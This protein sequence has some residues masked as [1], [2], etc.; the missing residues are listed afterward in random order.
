MGKIK[1]IQPK[2]YQEVGAEFI[3]FGWVAKSWLKSGSYVHNSI[4]LDFID[5]DGQ[6]FIGSSIGVFDD[7]SWLSKIR[8]KLKFFTI[9]KLTQVSS[10]FIA[11]SQGRITLRLS[12]QSKKQQ[13]FLPIIIK[14]SN[15]NFRVDPKIA[16][17]HKKIGKMIVQFER[18]LEKYNKKIEK[19][20][21]R[22]RKK[23]N[24]SKADDSMDNYV[25]D[26]ELAGGILNILEQ[27]ETM[28]EKDYIF[29][30]EDSEEKRLEERYKNAIEWRGPLL[31]GAF[32]RLNGFVFT[33]YSNEHGRHFH[34]IH[35]GR[36]I[37]ARFSFPEINLIDYKNS[38]TSIG[39]KEKNK[40]IEFLKDSKNFKK[41][42]EEFQRRDRFC[43]KN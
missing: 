43:N 20:Q 7:K 11:K 33:L 35:K 24:I 30:K 2:P 4:S 38:R 41:L 3:I 39:S 19:I 5:I 40:I 1:V 26:W 27:G 6:L 42:E 37:N 22:R 23:M 8:K 32:G 18:D 12:G 36:K 31:G 29:S 14:S 25:R 9:F 15:P 13:L 34:V 21:E 16:R 10:S 17:K 28:N